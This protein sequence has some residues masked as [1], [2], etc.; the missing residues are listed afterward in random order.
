MCDK[1]KNYFSD[2]KAKKVNYSGDR[3]Y[4]LRRQEL[5]IQGVKTILYTNFQ[6]V[7]ASGRQQ[8]TGQGTRKNPIKTVPKPCGR[9]GKTDGRFRENPIKTVLKPCGR[10]G[11]TG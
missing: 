1:I 2:G 10:Q 11:K 6:N 7:G 5:R 8:E 9:Q 4:S 3:S